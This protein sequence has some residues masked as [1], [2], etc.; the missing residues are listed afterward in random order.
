MG[1]M[2]GPF[3]VPP[4]GLV[5]KMIVSNAAQRGQNRGGLAS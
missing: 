3:G 2:F 5:Q 4:A 1:G